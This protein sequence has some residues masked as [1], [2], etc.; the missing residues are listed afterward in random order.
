MILQNFLIDPERKQALR[1]LAKVSD[2]TVSDV[3]RQLLPRAGV[4]RK[5]AQARRSLDRQITPLSYTFDRLKI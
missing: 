4:L 3:I 1:E 5:M 2:M